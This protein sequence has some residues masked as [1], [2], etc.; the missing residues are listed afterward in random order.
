MTRPSLVHLVRDPLAW[1]AVLTVGATVAIGGIVVGVL[2]SGLEQM[3]TNQPR[4]K[5]LA[6]LR[7]RLAN[8]A[9][10]TPP[11]TPEFTPLPRATQ[12]PARRAAGPEWQDPW[13]DPRVDRARLRPEPPRRSL[14]RQIDELE[15]LRDALKR[16]ERQLHR[17]TRHDSRWD[18]RGHRIRERR[19]AELE[20]EL[21]RVEH[22]I[23]QLE[24]RLDRLD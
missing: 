22:D 14:R 15:H 11:P 1:V 5:V 20:M 2:G 18:P 24:R 7:E 10:P 16:E 19:I 13:N 12:A 17:R 21:E 8:P 6:D 9:T 23:E 4:E 3:V